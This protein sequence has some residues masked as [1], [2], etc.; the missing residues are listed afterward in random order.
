MQQ[1]VGLGPWR[2]GHV[3][4]ARLA[5]KYNARPTAAPCV[6]LPLTKA[7]AA[8]VARCGT[9]KTAPAPCVRAVCTGSD[10]GANSWRCRST[11]RARSHLVAVGTARCYQ[12]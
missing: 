3:G 12:Q 7:W 11:E 6:V 9:A 1:Q 4:P 2:A 10:G 8:G 5:S